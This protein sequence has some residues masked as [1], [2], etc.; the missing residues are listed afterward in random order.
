MKA[1]Y[2]VPSHEEIKG[3]MAANNLTG[4]DMAALAGVSPRT[5]RHWLSPAGKGNRSIPWATWVLIQLLTGKINKAELVKSINQWKKE[6]TGI[7][8]FKRG[9]P[10]RPALPPIKSEMA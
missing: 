10:G 6:K 3:F 1:L 4:M 2:E 8:L 7:A 9:S 5:V